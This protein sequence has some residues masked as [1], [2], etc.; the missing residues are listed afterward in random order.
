MR[1]FSAC[2]KFSIYYK[3][4]WISRFNDIGSYDIRDGKRRE[5]QNMVIRL[6]K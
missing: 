1:P 5:A 2:P 3:N 4:D 6:R